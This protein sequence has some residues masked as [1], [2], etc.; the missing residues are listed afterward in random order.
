MTARLREKYK[1]DIA[2]ALMEKFKYGN[3]MQVP[4]L[5]K[6]V[7]NIGMGEAVQNIKALEA[8]VE[9]MT[10]IGGQKPIIRRAKKSISSFKLR[11]G[12]PVGCMVTLRSDVMYEFIDRFTN[13]ALPRIRDFRG[14]S[15]KSF[16]GRGNYS[17]GIREQIIFPEIEYDKVHSIHG[18]NICVVTTAKTDEEAR[19]LLRLMGFPYRN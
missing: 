7:L 14:L 9:E 19:E 15:P 4:R 13:V 18:M 6:V 2:P 17:M 12:V 10:L 1:K 8:A 16:D 3:V 5:V 11:E